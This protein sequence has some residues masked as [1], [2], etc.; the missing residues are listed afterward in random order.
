MLLRRPGIVNK[1]CGLAI[2]AGANNIPKPKAEG[3][4]LREARFAVIG[5]TLGR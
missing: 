2:R 5:V 4:N 1:H 3:C